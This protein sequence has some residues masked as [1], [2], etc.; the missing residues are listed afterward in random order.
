MKPKAHGACPALEEKAPSGGRGDGVQRAPATRRRHAP[1]SPRRRRHITLVSRRHVRD[2]RPEG[3]AVELRRPDGGSHLQFQPALRG[4]CRLLGA[5]V[6][7]EGGVR[8]VG[9]DLLLRLEHGQRAHHR[10]ERPVLR[11]VRQGIEGARLAVVPRRRGQLGLRSRATGWRGRLHRR[12]AP[13]PQP[14]GQ[15]RQPV[16]HQPG[17]G[18]GAAEEGLVL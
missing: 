4:I 13:R 3:P 8:G 10:A 14:A 18:G 11:A 1:P 6:L 7:P 9:R 5:D 16:L 15:E 17:V 12:D 2:A